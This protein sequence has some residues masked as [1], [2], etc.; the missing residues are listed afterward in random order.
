MAQRRTITAFPTVVDPWKALS[1]FQVGVFVHS[2]SLL[3]GFTPADGNTSKSPPIFFFATFQNFA[4]NSL[5]SWMETSEMTNEPLVPS[6][7]SPPLPPNLCQR[8]LFIYSL[9]PLL[10]VSCSF[11]S[12]DNPF[13]Q[14]CY[15][16]REMSHC[17]QPFQ[18]PLPSSHPTLPPPFSLPAALR[19]SPG[20]YRQLRLTFPASLWPDVNSLYFKILTFPLAALLLPPFL[21]P[22][23]F[24]LLPT[25]QRLCSCII[26][27]ALF[28]WRHRGGPLENE[29][30]KWLNIS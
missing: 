4:Q 6:S 27:L 5:D 12:F 23:C 22:F 7:T 9:P 24:R 19:Q 16:R 30:W 26:N 8:L 15:C 28:V 20:C 10:L 14:I 25:L 17:F 18:P 29:L 21:S 1:I 13:S 3:N 2:G 11:L